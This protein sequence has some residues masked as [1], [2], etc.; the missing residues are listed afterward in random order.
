[1]PQESIPEQFHP[2]QFIPKSFVLQNGSGSTLWR[3][4]L[5]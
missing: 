5:A 2:T 1:M 4:L 3:S